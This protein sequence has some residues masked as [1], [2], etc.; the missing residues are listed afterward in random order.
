MRRFN[1]TN[2]LPK[3]AITFAKKLEKFFERVRVMNEF[4]GEVTIYDSRKQLPNT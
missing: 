1:F 3:D 4:P 2:S